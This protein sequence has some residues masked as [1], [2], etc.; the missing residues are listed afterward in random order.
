MVFTDDYLVDINVD[1]SP[2][3]NILK[4]GNSLDAA[5]TVINSVDYIHLRM[6]KGFHLF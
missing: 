6:E 1:G 2:Y 4:V 3:L 5:L